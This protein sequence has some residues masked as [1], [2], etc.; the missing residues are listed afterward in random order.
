MVCRCGRVGLALAG[1]Q[2]GLHNL[3]AFLKDLA[4]V[5]AVAI[6]RLQD[7]MERYRRPCQFLANGPTEE[8]V[9]VED[10]DFGHIAGVVP[11]DDRLADV[12]CQ[13]GVEVPHTE[14]PD[15]IATHFA[16]FGHGQ[17]QQIQLLQRVGHLG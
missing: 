8:A 2:K 12:S 9:V 14:K 17:Q 16:W 10:P 5:S 4:E 7:V 6:S 11:D 13:G 1:T 15:A 3:C